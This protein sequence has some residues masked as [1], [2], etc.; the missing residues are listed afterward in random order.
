MDSRPPDPESPLPELTR[1]IAP[2]VLG[3]YTHFESTE[4]FAIRDGG[5]RRYQCLH[6][7]R[8]GRGSRGQD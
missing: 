3:Y 2:G 6:P 7:S 8:R 5:K 1:L 4:V